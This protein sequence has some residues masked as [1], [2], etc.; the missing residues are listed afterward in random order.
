MGRYIVVNFRSKSPKTGTP[1]PILESN[2]PINKGITN[3]GYPLIV[4]VVLTFLN[5]FSWHKTCD[6]SLKLIGDFYA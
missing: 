1:K 6:K 2:F 4:L 5:Q 3:S